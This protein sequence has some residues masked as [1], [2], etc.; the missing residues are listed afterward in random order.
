MGSVAPSPAARN[1][2][3]IY[4]DGFN[5][6]YGLFK[7]RPEWRWLNL[8]SF[9]EQLRLNEDVVKIR[10]FTAIVD[11]REHVSRKRDRQKR[12]LKA[13][14][15]LPKVEV[16]LGFFQSR[17]RT[18]QATCK[19][20]YREPEEKKTDVNIAVALI[21]DAMA[22][23]ADSMVVVTGDSDIQPAVAWIR[24]HYPAITLTVYV[25]ALPE[26]LHSRRADYYRQIRVTWRFLP[27]ENLLAH[28]LSASVTAADGQIVARPSEWA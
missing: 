6:Y 24:Q 23:R 11:E 12:F 26:A 20:V 3:I 15:S 28:Q 8:Q 18:C 5:F 9:F 17:E 25:P 4:I 19:R 13:L 16:I 14:S 21:D 27:T 1:R 22:N 7:K 10:Y 2:C